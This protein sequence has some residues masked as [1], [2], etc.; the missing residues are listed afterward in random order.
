MAHIQ[1]AAA[2]LDGDDIYET[3]ISLTGASLAGVS[4]AGVSLTVVSVLDCVIVWPSC[5]PCCVRWVHLRNSPCSIP[6]EPTEWSCGTCL[7]LQAVYIS[8]G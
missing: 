4:L 8:S 1:L 7:A 5:Q 2:D 6:A 3:D